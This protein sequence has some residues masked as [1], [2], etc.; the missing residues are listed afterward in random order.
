MEISVCKTTRA[1]IRGRIT[2]IA[3]IDNQGHMEN[4]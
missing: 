1:N 2:E 4:N 3:H